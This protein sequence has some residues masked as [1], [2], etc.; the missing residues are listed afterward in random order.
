MTTIARTSTSVSTLSTS[1][2]ADE[3][4]ASPATEKKV[5]DGGRVDCMG[6]VADQFEARGP[7]GSVKVG[8][9][10]YTVKNGTVSHGGKD[11][12]VVND[13]GEFDVTL[14]GA[15]H[16]G[17]V[18][19]LHGAAVTGTLSDGQK[20]DN[21]PTGL[22]KV[23]SDTFEVRAGEVT[24]DGKVLGTMDNDGRYNLSLNGQSVTGA[25]SNHTD[26][27]YVGVT[28]DGTKVAEVGSSATGEV[29]RN[30][31]S[32][33]FAGWGPDGQMYRSAGTGR[34]SQDPA[35]P[36]GHLSGP[37]GQRTGATFIEVIPMQGVGSPPNSIELANTFVRGG[38]YSDRRPPAN[39]PSGVMLTDF[40]GRVADYKKYGS[41]AD[42]AKLL[43]TSKTPEDFAKG[44]TEM[45]GYITS[46]GAYSGFGVTSAIDGS[47]KVGKTDFS[48]HFVLGNYAQTATYLAANPDV[49]DL[50]K[51][52][53]GLHPHVVAEW[54]FAN[55]G[56][57]EGRE[58]PQE[59][60]LLPNF[61]QVVGFG[62]TG[63]DPYSQ[64]VAQGYLDRNPDVVALAGQLG[65]DPIRFAI[66][67]Y[68]QVGRLEGRSMG[69]RNYIGNDQSNPDFE[70]YYRGEMSKEEAHTFWNPGEGSSEAA[71]ATGSSRTQQGGPGLNELRG[72]GIDEGLMKMISRLSPLALQELMKRLERASPTENL[73]KLIQGFLDEQRQAGFRPPM[74][75]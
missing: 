15:R 59:V 45:G 64:K 2:V 14:N 67:H 26:A 43:T 35:N 74:R 13:K 44:L 65:Q 69:P 60:T 22:V 11:V 63:S 25:L 38:P 72:E 28:S 58:W 41:E 36:F 55:Q 47:G 32:S 37:V 68:N 48:P 3:K 70:R 27:Q 4:V 33:I 73:A 29:T 7:T 12:G 56:K 46:A 53:P 71:P 42:V 34:I 61:N 39:A 62:A 66:H 10:E 54:H 6:P 23:G 49:Q 1:T 20:V 75:G 51:Q 16:T 5:A 18:S 52:H 50:A 8:T 9:T 21:R 19:D 17:R 40:S 31:P 24:R 30:Y 57:A